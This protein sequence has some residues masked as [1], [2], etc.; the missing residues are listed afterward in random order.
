LIYTARGWL[1]DGQALEEELKSGRISAVLDTTEP[2]TLP[3]ESPL[4]DL[5][6]VFLTPHIAGAMGGETRRLG[7]LAVD[8]VERYARGEPFRYAIRR[9]DL[10]RIA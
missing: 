6:N 4:Y 7:D 1:V 8:E 5:L 3:K 10:G 2:E 9:E